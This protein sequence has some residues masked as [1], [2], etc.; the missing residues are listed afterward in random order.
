[1]IDLKDFSDKEAKGLMSLVRITEDALAIST[2]KFDTSTGEELDE[3]VVGGNI[4][5]Y[6]DK[7]IELKAQINEIEAFIAKFETL[8][9]QNVEVIK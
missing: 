5:E 2:K 9:P 1:M 3:E 4:Q 7:V 8:K 6:K